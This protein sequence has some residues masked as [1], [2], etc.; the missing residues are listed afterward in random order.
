MHNCPPN[1]SITLTNI[2]TEVRLGIRKGKKGVVFPGFLLRIEE[3]RGL[4]SAIGSHPRDQTNGVS[5]G[6]S[7]PAGRVKAKH[8][9]AVLCK[10]RLVGAKKC[11][12]ILTLT[13]RKRDT[14]MSRSDHAEK[15]G[16]LE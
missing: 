15:T 16:S 10:T 13:Q 12:A 8:L 4:V 3:G 6:L 5:C 1:F 9:Y 2:P 14:L 7:K 11:A